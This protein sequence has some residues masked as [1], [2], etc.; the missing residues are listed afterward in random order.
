MSFFIEIEAIS[1]KCEIRCRF[2]YLFYVEISNLNAETD[3][4]FTSTL[5]IRLISWKSDIFCS[6]GCYVS[7]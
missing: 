7:K 2:A 4:E 3:L 5:G 6:S 1:R